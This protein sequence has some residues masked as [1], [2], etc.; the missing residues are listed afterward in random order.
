YYRIISFGLDEAVMEYAFIEG[1]KLD[2]KF[3]ISALASSSGLEAI[4]DTEYRSLS[5]NIP[6]GAFEKLCDDYI[7]SYVKDAKYKTLTAE[8]IIG[9]L[10]AKENEAKTL[11][12]ILSCKLS[13]IDP[14]KI[15]ERVRE[16]YV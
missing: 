11:K 3:F 16:S 10:L 2:N 9:Y 8:P 5:E 1:G 7:M 6:V 15:K 13:G 12:M 4:K 14:Q